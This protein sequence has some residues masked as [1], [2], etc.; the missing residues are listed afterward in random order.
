MMIC[1]PRTITVVIGGFE[2]LI[3]EGLASVLRDEPGVSLLACVD[4]GRLLERVVAREI[5]L[6]VIVDDCV[7][8]S[9]LM[10]VHAAARSA[11]VVVLAGPASRGCCRVLLGAGISSVARDGA[12]ASALLAVVRRVANGERM[13]VASDGRVEHHDGTSLTIRETEVL[14]HLARGC[15]YAQTARS[16]R[17]GARTVQTHALRGRRKLNVSNM[18][19]LV[20]RKL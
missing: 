14:W 12:S 3:A 20:G 15:T 10:R 4:N 9:A 6:L 7:D 1:G 16:L 17:I 19:E 18:R 5:P 11:A 2:V 13:L 8:V